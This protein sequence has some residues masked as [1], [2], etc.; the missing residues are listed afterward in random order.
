[1]K[2]VCFAAALVPIPYYSR[3]TVAAAVA[4]IAPVTAIS[5]TI[6]TAAVT[7]VAPGRGFR[8]RFWRNIRHI[9]MRDTTAE[10]NIASTH[11][12]LSYTEDVFRYEERER[13]R[14]EHE[15]NRR[16]RHFFDALRI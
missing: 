2:G 11:R 12:I 8:R 13:C 16:E 1:M 3:T 5:A 15:R 6:A 7:A 14:A 9:R 4:T 10:F